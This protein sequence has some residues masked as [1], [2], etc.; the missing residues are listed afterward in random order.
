MARKAKNKEKGNKAIARTKPAAAGPLASFEKQLSDLEQRFDALLSGGW[1]QPGQWE[2]PSLSD[3]DM[4]LP[5]VDV[6]DKGKKLVVRAE[7]PGVKK[8]NV[9]V[10][11]TDHSL[12]LRA[13]TREEKKE[14]KE[15]FVQRE[16]VSGSYV[17]TIPLPVA[18]D[19]TRAKAKMK[20]GI[21]HVVLPKAGKTDKQKVEVK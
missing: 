21:L 11:A 3:F 8:D 7:L 13:N 15:N 4:Q 19:G 12:T 10:T 2:M 18:V 1:L 5:R 16:I 6:L 9:E 14:E 17:R 20:N